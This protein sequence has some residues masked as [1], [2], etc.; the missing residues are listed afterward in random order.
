[1]VK[2]EGVAGSMDL[3]MDALAPLSLHGDPLWAGQSLIDLLE[4]SWDQWQGRLV[5]QTTYPLW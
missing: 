1:M 3:L 4:L 5:S 2:S